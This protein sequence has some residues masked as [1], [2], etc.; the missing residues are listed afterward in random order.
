MNP[1]QIAHRGAVCSGF[2]L[3]VLPSAEEEEAVLFAVILYLRA[4]VF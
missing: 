2:T 3:F 4:C 1:E